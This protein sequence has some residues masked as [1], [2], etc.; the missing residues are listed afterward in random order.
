MIRD[1]VIGLQVSPMNFVSVGAGEPR[2]P[3]R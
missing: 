3:T 2:V 1:G